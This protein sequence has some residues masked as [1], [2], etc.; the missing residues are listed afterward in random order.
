MRVNHA[1]HV[2][3]AAFNSHIVGL[4]TEGAPVAPVEHPPVDRLSVEHLS[5]DR[6]SVD[7]P[8]AGPSAGAR[9]ALAPPL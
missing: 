8:H 5:V 3:T 2:A 4:S 1:G 6:L 7:R 9:S